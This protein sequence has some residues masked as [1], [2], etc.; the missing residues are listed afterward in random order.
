MFMSVEKYK[1]WKNGKHW[2]Y[3]GRSRYDFWKTNPTYEQERLVSEQRQ[4]IGYLMFYFG[5]VVGF[6]LGGTL[7]L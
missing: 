6:I 3:I 4:Q 5:L 7:A 1:D 2:G